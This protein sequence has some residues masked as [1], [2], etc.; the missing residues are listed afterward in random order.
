M[1]VV[2]SAAGSELTGRAIADQLPEYAYTTVVT[3]LDRLARKGEVRRRL[4]ERVKRYSA[5]RGAGAHTAQAMRLALDAAN[6]PDDAL[7]RFVQD[8]PAG[9]LD[10]LR[11]AL[12]LKELKDDA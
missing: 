8:L 12:E 9:Q 3:V 11:N 6:D 4:D 7:L 1:D 5:V 2:W 10:V